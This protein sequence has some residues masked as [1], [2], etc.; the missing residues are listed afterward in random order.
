MSS[1]D[2]TTNPNVHQQMTK[3][4]VYPYNEIKLMKEWINDAQNTMDN[5]QN[6]YLSQSSHMVKKVNIAWF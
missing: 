4:S 2:T 6:N 5:A 1:K 3:L